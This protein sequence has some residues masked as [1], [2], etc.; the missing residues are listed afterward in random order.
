[1]NTLRVSR[2]LGASSLEEEEHT[3]SLDGKRQ[4]H[5]SLEDGTSYILMLVNGELKLS[6]IN[7]GLIV[8]PVSHGCVLISA[9]T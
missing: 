8:S 9:R 1:M 7:A 5:I 4:V 6:A 3:F 2:R